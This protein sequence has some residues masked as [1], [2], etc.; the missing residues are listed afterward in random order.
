MRSKWLLVVGLFV[1][2]AAACTVPPPPDPGGGGSVADPASMDTLAAGAAFG[3]AVESDGVLRCW[4]ANS[5]SQLGDGTAV[6]SSLAVPAQGLVDVEV[7]SAASAHACALAGDGTVW[8]WGDNDDGELGLGDLVGRSTPTQVPGLSN[9][10][11][12]AAGGNSHSCVVL[13][14]GTVKCSG[15]NLEGQLGDGNAPNASSTPVPV[16]GITTAEQVSV[17]YDHSCAVL[18]DGT[19]RCWG[20]NEKGQLGDGGTTDSDVPVLVAGLTDLVDIA[21]GRNHT[22][23]V[24]AAGSVFCWG[25]NSDG[26][27]G[28]GAS[29]ID[30]PTPFMVSIP[31]AS[32][33][34]AGNGHTCAA[35]AAGGVK[36]WGR[37]ADGQLGNGVTG[38]DVPTPVDVVGLPAASSAVA[39]GDGHS[40]ARLVNGSV[41]CWGNNSSGQL[42]NG[43]TVSS[44][45]PVEVD[46]FDE[47]DPSPVVGAALQVEMGEGVGCAVRDDGTVRCWGIDNDA[48]GNGDISR[49]DTAFPVQGLTGA[50]QVAVTD[51]ATACALLASGSIRC[52]GSDRE[53]QLGDSAPMFSTLTPVDPV[54]GINTATQISAGT[55][56]FCARLAG[57]TVE[58]WGN[59]FSNQAGPGAAAIYAPQQITGLPAGVTKV[60]TGGGHSCALAGDGTVW[61]W[62]A[63]SYGQLGDGNA[64]TPSATPHLVVGVTTA[65]DVIAGPSHTCAILAGGTVNCWGRDSQGQLGNDIALVDSPIPVAV[66]GITTATSLAAG[67]AHTCAV[68]ADGTGRCWGN[69]STGELGMGNVTPPQPTPVRVYGLNNATQIATDDTTGRAAFLDETTCA[70]IVDGTVVCW[71][72]GDQ[73][74]R[75]VEPPG[76][77]VAPADPVVNL[78]GATNPAIQLSAGED[79]NC[80]LRQDT[81]LNCW[82]SN[83][84]GQLGDGTTVTP[85]L[86][87]VDVVG[88]GGTGLLNGVIDISAGSAHTCAALGPAGAVCWGSG[89]DGQLGDGIAAGHHF[90]GSPVAVVGIPD[91]AQV[92]AGGLFSCARSIAGD[93]YCWGDGSFGQIGDGLGIDQTAPQ[94]V[95]LPGDAIDLAVGAGH[96]CAVL[97]DQS[98]WC[99]G[100]NADG[101]LGVGDT[102]N[103]LA[104]AR[105]LEY[106]G[107][108]PPL[109]DV[110]SVVAGTVTTCFTQSDEDGACAGDMGSQNFPAA[111]ILTDSAWAPGGDAT[112]NHLCS[113]DPDLAGLTHP[114]NPLGP[115]H[116]GCLGNYSHGQTGQPHNNGVNANNDSFLPVANITSPAQLASGQHHSCAALADGTVRC[117]GGGQLGQ[118]GNGSYDDFNVDIQAVAGIF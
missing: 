29:G 41:Y 87:P 102:T 53:G 20:D 31:P 18:A 36:C 59:N 46:D 85:R 109:T 57:G 78:N 58:C 64:P 82:G 63:N 32:G 104:P 28:N 94:Q 17:G 11:D 12:L 43:G 8:C 79:H 106:S 16:T 80:V 54:A 84:Y 44:P 74:T 76:D 24:D 22:C 2:V 51:D 107:G 56:H 1:L 77:A 25:W 75:G 3:C 27:I 30:V 13:G 4:G 6:D 83:T 14:D 26:Q 110:Q 37:N 10:V 71:G 62:G 111:F 92:G 117:W 45:I 88:I 55:S 50:T 67:R 105:V 68:L 114:V 95:P 116:V 103:R 60:A 118:M 90:T 9:V 38:P 66:A 34:A 65:T 7:V 21:A 89:D 48:L 93:V 49:L 35:I 86:T 19:A 81:T 101:Q 98:A 72:D 115:D 97:D 99:W 42:G 52:W 33:V 96:A 40:C 69:N 70:L 108:F 91:A 100:S 5:D 73:G 15:D 112:G 47:P 23:A 113:S 39:A 61:C